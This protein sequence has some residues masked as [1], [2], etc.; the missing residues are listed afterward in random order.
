[1][2]WVEAGYFRRDSSAIVA[3]TYG[4]P[5]RSLGAPG[6]LLDLQQL[7]EANHAKVA[8]LE[9]E[10]ELELDRAVEQVVVSAIAVDRSQAVEV[11]EARLEQDVTSAQEVRSVGAQPAAVS[12]DHRVD[13][14]EN[15]QQSL[16]IVGC[17]G[18]TT[19]WSHVIVDA[20]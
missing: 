17:S 11:T 3:S 19:S 14:A 12:S 13:V 15:A 8:P 20:P 10:L 5:A 7:G 18:C 16:D 9:L 1:M 4:M 2:G 6:A